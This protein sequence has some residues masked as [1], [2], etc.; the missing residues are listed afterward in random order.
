MRDL[1]RRDTEAGSDLADMSENAFR[2][3]KR[4]PLAEQIA[5]TVAKAIA[6]GLLAPEER[7]TETALAERIGV[8]RAP[9][10]EALKILQAQGI[11]TADL[12]RGFRVA[13]FDDRTIEQTLEVR[14]SLEAILLR[15]AIEWWRENDPLATALNVP[16]ARMY[17]AAV[18]D[19][20]AASLEADL[21]F[22]KAI[23]EAAHN[24]IAEIL[25]SAIARN[26]LI[27][28]SFHRYRA[29]DLHAI[30]SHHETLRD[31]I[32]DRIQSDTDFRS[33]REELENHL[34]QVYRLRPSDG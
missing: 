23:A 27:I 2:I 24:H 17:E 30:V 26:V 21:N 10:R 16:I 31:F 18:A 6:T 8:S 9:I 7:I 13:S 32:R 3:P 25:W 11:V 12:S 34:L 19:D 33:L 14:L 5:D 29:D 4:V 15:D 28:F 22:H 1:G 20:R